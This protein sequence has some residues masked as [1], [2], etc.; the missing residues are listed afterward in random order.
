MLIQPHVKLRKCVRNR[1]MIKLL[2]SGDIGVTELPNNTN[3]NNYLNVIQQIKV[4]ERIEQSH[5]I[6]K[7][8]QVW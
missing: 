6:L 5:T 8:N 4:I 7:G 1:T 3:A 2:N